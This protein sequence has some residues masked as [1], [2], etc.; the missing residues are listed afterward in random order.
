MQRWCLVL[1]L[2]LA[3]CSA[4]GCG[5]GKVSTFLVGSDPCVEWIFEAPVQWGW[6]MISICNGFA[7]GGVNA[8]SVTD[9]GEAV[10]VLTNY[11]GSWA[12]LER[13][14]AYLLDIETGKTLRKLRGPYDTLGDWF[15]YERTAYVEG[16]ENEQGY[17]FAMNLAEGTVKRMKLHIDPKWKRKKAFFG[18]YYSGSFLGIPQMGKHKIGTYEIGNGRKIICGKDTLEIQHYVTPDRSEIRFIGHL[19]K[20]SDA[21]VIVDDDRRL[22]FACGSYLICID[23]RKLLSAEEP[24]GD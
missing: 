22:I 16:T 14:N 20:I 2:M 4:G 19:A 23:T 10:V 12:W 11:G 7:Y 3:A 24:A 18:G 9:D 1:V 17:Y 13:C 15:L 8:A 21:D 6:C 5:G